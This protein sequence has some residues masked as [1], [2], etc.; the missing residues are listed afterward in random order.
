MQ[1]SFF[2]GDDERELNSSY[3]RMLLPAEVLRAAGHDIVLGSS[4]CS[5]PAGTRDIVDHID[6]SLVRETVLVERVMTRERARHLRLAGAKRIVLTLDDHYAAIPP[7]QQSYETW[8]VRGFHD[9]LLRSLP[10][11]DQ[12]VVA[13]DYLAKIY[14][15]YC[16]NKVVVIKNY[17][18]WKKWEPA[19]VQRQARLAAGGPLA[20]GWGGTKL[21]QPSWNVSVL[22][23]LLRELQ[24]R[25]GERIKFLFYNKVADLVLNAAGLEFESYGLQTLEGWPSCV[26]NFDLG[27]IPLRGEYDAARSHLK[28]LEF[29]TLGIPWVA[30]GLP[31]VEHAIGGWKVIGR[32]HNF[33]VKE[34]RQ[35]WEAG[36]SE[37]IE[38]DLSR[39][40]YRDYGLEWARQWRA[41]LC[42]VPYEEALWGKS[43]IN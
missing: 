31:P 27:L 8:I 26:A 10:L 30:D 2:F 4:L 37:L 11:I 23:T 24:L 19:Y 18:D 36:L 9:E 38:S 34:E 35:S 5:T 15:K 16:R 32:W 39:E 6:Y 33:T 28:A 3:Y 25:Y 41:E 7:G 20:I 22:P 17:L 13:S 40:C 29:A 43:R 14:Q 1:A 21:H 12:L 42:Q